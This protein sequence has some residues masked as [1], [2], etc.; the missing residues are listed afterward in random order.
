VDFFLLCVEHKRLL[1]KAHK[2]ILLKDKD[3]ISNLYVC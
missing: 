1:S 2:S 3:Y